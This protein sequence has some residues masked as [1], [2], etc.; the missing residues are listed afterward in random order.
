M[1]NTNDESKRFTG[2]L[3]YANI[4]SGNEPLKLA[5]IKGFIRH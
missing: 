5:Q 3:K 2:R 1:A 4:M